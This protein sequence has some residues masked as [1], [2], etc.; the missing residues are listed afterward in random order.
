MI[1]HSKQIKGQGRGHM[2]G[3]PTINLALPED[4]VLDFGIYAAWVVVDGKTYKGALH[5]GAVPT[6]DQKEKTMEVHL[7]DITDDTAPDTFD[8][9]IEIDIVEHLR[10][11]KNF[12]DI[13]DL[14]N[15]IA[16]DIEQV[17]LILK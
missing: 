2:I 9:V 5:Y 4:L 1:V 8:N 15:Q 6:F 7:L 13:E 16:R 3:F 14:M 17:R 11:V 12:T 10:D